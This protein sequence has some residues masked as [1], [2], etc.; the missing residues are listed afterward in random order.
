MESCTTKTRNKVIVLA[1]KRSK[2]I[3]ENPKKNQIRKILVDGC[4]IKNGIRCDYLIIDK[5]Q[6]EYF[7]ELKG[8]NVKHAFAQLI[9]SIKQLSQDEKHHSKQSFVISTVCPLASTAI[10]NE[11][12]KFKKL[13][14]SSL[15]VK[16]NQ[17]KV[18]L[19]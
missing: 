10:Q 18:I 3:F 4:A 14:N 1:E 16:N 6:S 9:E 11:K 17:Y 15:V 13:F 19:C 5:S 2:I 7:V 8:S 12:I